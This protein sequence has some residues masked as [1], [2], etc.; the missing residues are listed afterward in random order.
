MIFVHRSGIYRYESGQPELLTKEIPYFWQTINWAAQQTIW[1]EIDEEKRIVRCGL[2]VNGSAV[3]NVELTISYVEGWAIP[4]HFDLFGKMIAVDACRKI[5]IND[6][7]ANCAGRIERALPPP[8]YPPQGVTG[9]EQTGGDFY[10][11]QFVY[12]SS[13]ADGSVQAITPGVYNDNGAGIH[14]HYRTVSTGAM[15]ALSKCEGLNLNAREKARSM[16]LSSPAGT[17]SRTGRRAHRRPEQS[18]CGPSTSTRAKV[19]EFQGIASR[20]SM[21]TGWSS[22]RTAQFPTHGVN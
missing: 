16:R 14:G 12:G 6:I 19:Q 21:S 11:S 2:P 10:Q 18:R 5:S 22:F 15:Q 1:L 7:A 8:P 17:F 4:I 9:I 3:P 20:G 13:A